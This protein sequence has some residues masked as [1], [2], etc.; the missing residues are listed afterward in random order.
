MV[1]WLLMRIS[2]E[3]EQISEIEELTGKKLSKNGNELIGEVIEIAKN[4]EDN[5]PVEISC[6]PKTEK[7]ASETEEES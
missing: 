1:L 3:D 4:S 7:L 6:C 5:G 2:L